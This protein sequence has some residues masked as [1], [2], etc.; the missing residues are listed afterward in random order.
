MEENPRCSL[1]FALQYCEAEP[2]PKCTLIPQISKFLEGSALQ[3]E[4]EISLYICSMEPASWHTA[5][6]S[7]VGGGLE[8][9]GANLRREADGAVPALNACGLV[10]AVACA[11]GDCFPQRLSLRK[12]AYTPKACLSA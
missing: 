4:Q 11:H 7:P 12:P 9:G 5:R 1:L 10:R 2:T 6:R 8:R 3:K